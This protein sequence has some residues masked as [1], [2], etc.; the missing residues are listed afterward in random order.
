MFSVLYT[1]SKKFWEH[2]KSMQA[3]T[4]NSICLK[5]SGMIP[6]IAPI[7]SFSLNAIKNGCGFI[8]SGHGVKFYA[9]NNI[10]C[11]L[12]TPCSY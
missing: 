12:S 7:V 1:K 3:V 11:F 4:V 6:E 2:L 5:L 8:L 9:H 10:V